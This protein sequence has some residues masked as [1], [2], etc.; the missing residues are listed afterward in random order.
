MDLSNSHL[1]GAIVKFPKDEFDFDPDWEIDPRDVIIMDKLGT[2]LQALLLFKKY[3]LF[4]SCKEP[5]L[6]WQVKSQRV[7][8]G[9]CKQV[10]LRSTLCSSLQG[11]LAV[12]CTR[13][14]ACCQ[15]LI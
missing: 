12:V 10:L 15:S 7:V 5:N 9:Q 2:P 6:S 4:L 1:S 11:Y 13:E 8:Q 14:Q 3:L